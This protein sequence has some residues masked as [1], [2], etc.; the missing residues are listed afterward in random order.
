M[1]LNMHIDDISYNGALVAL[2]LIN[3]IKNLRELILLLLLMII[4]TINK[5]YIYKLIFKIKDFSNYENI[6]L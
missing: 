4:V 3:I 5:N 1:E 6:I 2:K